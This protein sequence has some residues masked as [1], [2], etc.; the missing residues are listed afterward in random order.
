MAARLQQGRARF[1][2]IGLWFFLSLEGTRDSVG[3]G[4]TGTETPKQC[5][6]Y[7]FYESIKQNTYGCLGDD[8]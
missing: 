1:D 8:V 5:N 2:V 7:I 3:A 4:L 6:I